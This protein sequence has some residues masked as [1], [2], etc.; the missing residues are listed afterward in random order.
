MRKS[1][2][3]PNLLRE[4][5]QHLGLIGLVAG[6]DAGPIAPRRDGPLE[7]AVHRRVSIKWRTCSQ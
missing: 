4:T 1:R 6:A 5:V 7:R 3:R 2:C